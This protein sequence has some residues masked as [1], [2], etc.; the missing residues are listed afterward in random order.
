MRSI[1]LGLRR[2]SRKAGLNTIAGSV[3]NFTPRQ[4]VTDEELKHLDQELP[5]RE[6]LTELRS[7]DQGEDPFGQDKEKTVPGDSFG[8][9]RNR[10]TFYRPVPRRPLYGR[11]GELMPASTFPYDCY[12]ALTIRHLEGRFG[13]PSDVVLEAL[14]KAK[15]DINLA[16]MSLEERY[17]P[18]MEFGAYGV[19]CLES[20]VPETFCMVSFNL[21]SAKALQDD[22]TLD[23]IHELTLSA[24]E[25]PLDVPRERLIDKFLNEWTI[26]DG[27][28]CR[29]LMEEY[30]LTVSRIVL[31]P[32][33]DYSVQGFHILNPV[34]ETAPNIGTAA[35]ACCLDLRTGIH[36]RFRFH[37][38]RIADSVSEHILHEL[39]H[40]NQG[41]HILRQPFWFRPEYSVE[42]YIR[43]KESLL[44]PSASTFEMRYGFLF[45]Q[46][47]N[48]PTHCNIVEMEKLKIAQ[49][50]YEKHYE[51][52]TAPG[53]WITSDGANLQTVAAAGGGSNVAG[54]A[55]H[56]HSNESNSINSAME[57]RAG[58]LRKMLAESMQ[59]HGDRVFERFYRNNYF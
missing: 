57:T 1:I 58:P 22:D 24:A 13:A 12:N 50:K 26:E 8:I 6:L 4:D 53:R 51:D 29:T 19:V 38:E 48:L 34:K 16:V 5:P 47:Y 43:F 2:S 37:V 23:V 40:Y 3:R 52:F 59:K 11:L 25:M 15:G 32:H 55:M 35:A 45:A 31:L 42:E 49:H 54:G 14:Q 17:G 7:S 27:T 21:P 18:A 36:N 39:C 28:S 33:G 20:Y 46:M 10:V 9:M 44:Q 30:N 41:V 56:Y